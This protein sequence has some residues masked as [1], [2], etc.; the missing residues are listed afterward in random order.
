M[1]IFCH[2]VEVIDK[3]QS[4]VFISTLIVSLLVFLSL[5]YGPNLI[6]LTRLCS[7]SSFSWPVRDEYT[8]YSDIRIVSKT[9]TTECHIVLSPS[10]FVSAIKS[11]FFKLCSLSGRA[12]HHPQS[13]LV[14]PTRR[15]RRHIFTWPYTR[16]VTS[17]HVPKHRGL[18]NTH[19]NPISLLTL[20]RNSQHE[21][22]LISE[23][24]R[25]DLR[26]R[27]RHPMQPI[28]SPVLRGVRELSPNVHKMFSK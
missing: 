23:V 4:P 22:H 13:D 20:A 5:L 27:L 17:R 7:R 28:A 6:H 2:A 14:R 26:F 18:Y 9:L 24:T 25:I 19:T 21:T 15:R 11:K 10:R 12:L 8:S 16:Q 3:S 1:C